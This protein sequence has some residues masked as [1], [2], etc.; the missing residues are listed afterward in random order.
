MDS[1]M[2]KDIIKTRTDIRKKFE[3]LRRRKT[4]SQGQLENIFKPITTPLRKLIK[5]KQL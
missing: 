4:Q 5:H 2:V 3:A 1:K